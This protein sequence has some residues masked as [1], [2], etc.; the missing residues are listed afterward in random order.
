MLQ[1]VQ[2]RT[3]VRAPFGRMARLPI[4]V[5]LQVPQ[6]HFFVKGAE[7]GGRFRRLPLRKK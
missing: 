1:N 4:A 5:C 3:A 2:S 7:H 6:I